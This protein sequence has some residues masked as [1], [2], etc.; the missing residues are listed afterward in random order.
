MFT[1][2]AVNFPSHCTGVKCA[3][4]LYMCIDLFWYVVVFYERLCINERVFILRVDE[5]Y[6]ISCDFTMCFFVKREVMCSQRRTRRSA[7]LNRIVLCAQANK[8][9]A[10]TVDFVSVLSG[11]MWNRCDRNFLPASK[12]R[13]SN[14]LWAIVEQA[15]LNTII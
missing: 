7:R 11:F 13:G 4:S 6:S 10:L 12:S 3:K 5:G 15:H 8:I 1:L 9:R 2:E 14:Q